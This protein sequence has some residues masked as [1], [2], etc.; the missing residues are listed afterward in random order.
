MSQQPPFN[1]QGPNPNYPQ[2]G[3]IV[4]GHQWNGREWVPAGVPAGVGFTSGT[5]PATPSKP[6]WKKWW[7]WVL[8]VIALGG[9]G[10]LLDGGAKETAAPPATA[11]TAAKETIPETTLT[12]DA[13]SETE[14]TPEVES[15]EP[16]EPSKIATSVE[17]EPEPTTEA[18]APPPSKYGD[19]TESQATFVDAVD[20]AR[21]AYQEAKTDLQKSKILKDRSRDVLPSIG[22]SDVSSWVGVID[23]VGANGEGKAYVQIKISDNIKVKTWN[24][25]FSDMT[26][27]TLIPET[28]AVYDT[29][30]GLVP[31][32]KVVFSGS[33]QAQD[34]APLYATNIT[35]TFS[36]R[37]PEFLFKFTSIKPA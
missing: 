24:N 37:T 12:A 32:D 26:H 22:G 35:D 3:Q 19:Y 14:S 30:L 29:L 10:N 13:V 15:A 34:G 28:S 33:F 17:P 20:A 25:A 36:A 31:G 18:P 11:S 23:D 7:V 21:A 4:N 1:N 8:I 27:D 6:W 5:N 16:V 9:I 2:V